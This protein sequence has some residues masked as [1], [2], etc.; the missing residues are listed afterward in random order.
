MTQP[1]S[2]WLHAI[3]SRN[4]NLKTMTR[5]EK[6]VAISFALTESLI[7]NLLG[8]ALLLYVAFTLSWWWTWLIVSVFP[9]APAIGVI[10]MLCLR[11][12][13]V[14][15]LYVTKYPID[16][17]KEPEKKPSI[18]DKWRRM[19]TALVQW[20]VFLAFGWLIGLALTL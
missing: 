16:K 2:P 11:T 9:T 10:Q 20:T 17:D 15:F 14:A 6:V 7:R 8:I 1:S 4:A 18:E 5:E 3:L 19:G 12:F 13:A